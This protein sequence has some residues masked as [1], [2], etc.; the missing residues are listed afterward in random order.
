AHREPDCRLLYIHGGAFVAGSARTNGSTILPTCHLSGVDA[1]AVDYPKAP[2]HTFPAA[3][4]AIEAV[5]RHLLDNEARPEKIIVVG[6][7]AGGNLAATSLVRWRAR[8]LPLPAGAILLSPL[9]DGAGL[10]DT[11]YTLSNIDPLISTTRPD[12]IK[13]LFEFYVNGRSVLDPEVSPVYADWTD[14]P[15]LLIHVGAREVLLGDSARLSEKARQGGVDVR[16]RVFDGMFHLFHMN[17]TLPEAKAAHDDMAA[18]V[19]LQMDLEGRT[20]FEAA[21]A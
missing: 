20:V 6:D 8:G 16:L 11:V 13:K 14:M 2:E 21:Q 10:S 12:H 17:W 3:H 5:Y 4:E 9:A 18:F 1:V 15:P 7:S 19:R